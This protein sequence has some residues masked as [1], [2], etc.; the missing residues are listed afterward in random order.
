LLLSVGLALAQT[1]TA[2]NGADVLS[3]S[4]PASVAP[5]ATFTATI[6]M[7]NTGANQWTTG[8]SYNL[9]SESP[10]NNLRWLAGGRIALPVDP[11]NPGETAAFTTT[12]TAPTTPGVYTFT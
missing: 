4:A 10:R 3:I 5:G 6:T 8:S 9:G 11:I 2:Q 12:F 1:A 7:T